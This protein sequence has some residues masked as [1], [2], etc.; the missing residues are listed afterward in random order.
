MKRFVSLIVALALLLTMPAASASSHWHPKVKGSAPCISDGQTAQ[1]VLTWTVTN[2]YDRHMKILSSRLPLHSTQPPTEQGRFVQVVKVQWRWP[3]HV[4]TGS[5][6][7][8][9]TLDGQ[10]SLA[11]ADNVATYSVLGS[12]GNT[13]VNYRVPNGVASATVGRPWSITVPITS[14]N[15][16]L[17]VKATEADGDTAA[18]MTCEISIGGNV[19]ASAPGSGAYSVC[20]VSSYP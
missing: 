1:Y 12:G 2:P 13:Y 5:G 14:A 6:Y 7:A 9:L 8:A 11:S 17:E 15:Q 18:Q 3:G 10:C 19:V 16:L 20:D 4:R